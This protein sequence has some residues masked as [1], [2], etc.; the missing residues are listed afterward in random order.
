MTV[1][2]KQCLLAYLGYYSGQVDGIWGPLSQNAVKDFQ[3]DWGN[4]EL[5]ET[6]KQAVA[7][8]KTEKEE[9]ED[10]WCG[11][12]YFTRQ[13]FACKCGKCGGFPAEPDRTM[14]Q[15]A[16]DV[17]EHF[18]AP[19][20]PSSG[21]RCAAHNANVGGVSGSRHLSGKAVDFCI[22]GRSAAQILDFVQKD[23]RTRYAY[24][25]DAAYVHMDVA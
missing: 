22:R 23:P 12:R 15:L 5:E 17:R 24:A 13:E 7:G 10:F 4:G 3:T 9:T 8:G 25:I 1:K 14:V 6:L 11:I 2:Q 19:M 20:I 18:G 21:V 16:E